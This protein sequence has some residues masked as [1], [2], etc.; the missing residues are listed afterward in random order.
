MI[1][2]SSLGI[3]ETVSDLAKKGRFV[4]DRSDKEISSSSAVYE[5]VS[6]CNQNPEVAGLDQNA[7]EISQSSSL[8]TMAAI[9]PPSRPEATIGQGS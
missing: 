4:D 3:D 8:H 2:N 6:Q 5:K 7:H 9:D 1:D